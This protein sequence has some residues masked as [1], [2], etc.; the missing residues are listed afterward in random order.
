MDLGPGTAQRLVGAVD[1]MVKR[2]KPY[3]SAL[4]EPEAAAF[5]GLDAALTLARRTM[6][7]LTP[8]Q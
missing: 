4:T 6:N 2:F 8:G 5:D 1:E 7:E 3:R